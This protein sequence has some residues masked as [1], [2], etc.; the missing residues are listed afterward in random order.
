MAW[1][2]VRHVFD[3]TDLR[4]SELLLALA[5]ADFADADGKCWPGSKRL[6]ARIRRSP[7][8]VKELMRSLEEKGVMSRVGRKPT[9][10]QGWV[11]ILQLKGATA[12]ASFEGATASASFD[13]KDAAGDAQSVRDS[14]ESMRTAGCALKDLNNH[15]EQPLLND[16]ENE[17]WEALIEELRERVNPQSFQDWFADLVF[18]GIEGSHVKLA[19]SQIAA[20]W[21]SANY[22]D[23]LQAAIAAA[24]LVGAKIQW[25]EI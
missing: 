2:W 21:I 9:A 6:A 22:N 17:F 25:R 8:R 12:S 13:R 11:P 10:G 16:A 7:R 23:R 15:S 20:E 14:A 19:T 18:E 24:G 4:N 1:Q 5:I 3:A